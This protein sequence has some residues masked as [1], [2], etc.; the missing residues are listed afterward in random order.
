[1]NAG[2]RRRSGV[3]DVGRLYASDEHLHRSTDGMRRR[4][5]G[6]IAVRTI[7]AESAAPHGHDLARLSRVGE[8][9]E[10]SVDR[11]LY[12]SLVGAIDVD[13]KGARYHVDGRRRAVAIVGVG[14]SRMAGLDPG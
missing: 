3:S 7:A 10:R 2:I 13:A 5:I 12:H 9:D 8:V 1:M 11:I 6:C 4:G 14:Q